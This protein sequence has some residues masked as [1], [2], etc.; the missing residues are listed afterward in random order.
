MNTTSRFFAHKR[1]PRRRRSASEM[2]RSGESGGVVLRRQWKLNACEG[3]DADRNEEEL[4]ATKAGIAGMGVLPNGRRSIETGRPGTATTRTKIDG[5]KGNGDIGRGLVA[6]RNGELGVAALKGRPQSGQ[7]M[8]RRLADTSARP[9]LQTVTVGEAKNENGDGLDRPPPT[10]PLASA[11]VL[12]LQIY[13]HL[14][15]QRKS[16]QTLFLRGSALSLLRH[17]GQKALGRIC[18]PNFPRRWTSTLRKHTIHAS[19]LRR[20]LQHPRCLL[21]G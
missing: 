5:T 6:E 10:L 18:Q 16:L 15:N 8:L 2:N 4:K 9:T 13:H 21:R 19:M 7:R 3:P 12:I 1:W 11:S 20:C 14:S 17:P